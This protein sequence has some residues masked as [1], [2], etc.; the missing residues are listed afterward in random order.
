MAQQL[1][2]KISAFWKERRNTLNGPLGAM[3]AAHEDAVR[4]YAELNSADVQTDLDKQN[5]WDE[6]FVKR[7]EK[8]M[9][10]WKHFNFLDDALSFLGQ[11]EHDEREVSQ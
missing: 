9:Q 5:Q 3:Y 4:E 6:V 10:I 2:A 11:V 8:G 1:I 7:M